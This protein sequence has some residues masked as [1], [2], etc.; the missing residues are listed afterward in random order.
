[1]TLLSI[2][3]DTVDMNQN[4]L[5]NYKMRVLLL[6]FLLETWLEHTISF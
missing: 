1:M 6:N 5:E 4:S 3:K 2:S